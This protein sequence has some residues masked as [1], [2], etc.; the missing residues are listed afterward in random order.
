M[1]SDLRRR[2]SK[3]QP[4]ATRVDMGQLQHIAQ[5]RPISCIVTTINDDM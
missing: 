4:A 1:E 3:D 5:E 2:Q